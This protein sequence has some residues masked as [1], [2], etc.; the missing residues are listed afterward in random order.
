MYPVT[1]FVGAIKTK[2]LTTTKVD[3]SDSI[4]I[5]ELFIKRIT[6]Y[7]KNPPLISNFANVSI[8]DV[9]VSFARTFFE[10]NC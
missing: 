8:C 5:K 4:K 10:E 9:I 3:K 2:I 7:N 1:V 6:K